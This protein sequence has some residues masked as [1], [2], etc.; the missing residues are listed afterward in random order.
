MNELFLLDLAL[1]LPLT[2]TLLALIAGVIGAALGGA[3]MGIKL[4]GADLGKEMTSMMGA[5]VEVRLEE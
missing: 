5:T 1:V 3:A 4:G 2:S